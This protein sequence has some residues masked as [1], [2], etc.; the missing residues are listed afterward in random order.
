MDSH[1]NGRNS[2][3]RLLHLVS[4]KV[5]IEIYSTSFDSSFFIT[6]KTAGL[7]A[8]C[9]SG[10]ELEG[11]LLVKDKIPPIIPRLITVAGTSRPIAI[12]ERY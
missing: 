3:K 1:H 2:V 10:D 12:E 5:R 4:S 9:I 6:G 7:G 8:K 11:R